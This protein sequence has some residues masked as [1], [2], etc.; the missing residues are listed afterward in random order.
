MGPYYKTDG[1]RAFFSMPCTHRTNQHEDD[2]DYA[3]I[4]ALCNKL[5]EIHE[6]LDISD[7]SNSASSFFENADKFE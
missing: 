6:C 2:I 1:S 3:E 4:E 7:C 5:R